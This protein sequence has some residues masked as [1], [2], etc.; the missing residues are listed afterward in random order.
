V[1]AGINYKLNKF[2]FG[3]R[4][5]YVWDRYSSPSSSDSYK[6]KP[7]FLTTFTTVYTPDK[8]NEF[9]LI[10]DNV[11]NRK[12]YLSNTMSNHGTYYSTPTNFLFTYTYKF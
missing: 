1:T 9:A 6:I 5:S 10:V 7:Y 4:G 12:D 2:K 8:N 3:L 11:L